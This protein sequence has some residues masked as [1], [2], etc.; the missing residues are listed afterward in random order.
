MEG[1]Q[2]DRV[3]AAAAEVIAKRGYNATTVDHIVAA[4]G[5][6]VGTFYSL[7]ANKEDCFLQAYE[8]IVARGRER[9]AAALHLGM[10]W[11]EQACAALSAL[12]E[13]IAARPLEAR[14]A[15]V[16]A[17]TAG[18]VALARHAETLRSIDPFLAEAR[19]SSPL[20]DQLPGTLETALVGGV[21]WL[22]QQRIVMGEAAGIEALLPELAGIVIEPYF[23]E[24]EVQ[25]C[26]AATLGAPAA[27]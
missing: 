15:L 25:R 10:P 2:R 22:L 7:F 3:L 12:L 27:G 20:A 1:H 18:P 6:G 16:E 5:I 21:L 8:R 17:Q 4:A 14:L 23:G 13:M 24:A 9:V 19:R 11:P 26:L